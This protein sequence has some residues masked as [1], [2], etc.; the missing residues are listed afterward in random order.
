MVKATPMHQWNSA[1]RMSGPGALPWPLHSSSTDRHSPAF[2]NDALRGLLGQPRQIPGQY[3]YDL[4]GCTLFERAIESPNY[5]LARTELRLIHEHAAELARRMGPCPEV[6]EWGA[7]SMRVIR[8]LIEE[9]DQPVHYLPIG[10]CEGHLQAC[11]SG[12]QHDYPHLQ[13]TPQVKDYTSALPLPPPHPLAGRR[14]GLLGATTLGQFSPRSL[15]EMLA[16]WARELRGG[17]L[18]ATVDQLCQ[19]EAVNLAYNDAQGLMAA[20]NLNLLQRC[21]QELGAEI[22]RSGFRHVAEYRSDGQRIELQLLSLR[23]QTIRLGWQAVSH[24]V[25]L[26]AGEPIETLRFHQRPVEELMQWARQAG[27]HP[28]P[29][30][31]DPDHRVAVCWLTAPPA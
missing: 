18:I 9:M 14:I 31:N 28:G 13:I 1:R 27:F 7:G 10:I 25:D 24:E 2:A 15:Q 19:P 5:Y 8:R 16:H 21:R 12:L 22:E 17:A 29:V 11:A 20:F 6:V 30:W 4:K 3:L 26:L 23:R